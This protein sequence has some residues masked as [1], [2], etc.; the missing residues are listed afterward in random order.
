M[1]CLTMD[2]LSS[3][4]TYSASGGIVHVVDSQVRESYSFHD[5]LG[6]GSVN[7]LR[8]AADGAV[9]IATDSGLSRLKAGRIAT[10]DTRTGLP[11]DRVDST[12]IDDDAS[13]WLYSICGLVRIARQDLDAWT[14]AVDEGKTPQ[15]IQP[16][17]LDSSDGVR[18]AGALGTFSPHIT[19]S[20]DGKLWFMTYDGLSVVDPRHLPFNKLPPPVHVEQVVADHKTYEA[21]SQLHLPPLVR[22]L[23]IDYTALSL[24]APEKVRFRYKLEGRDHDWQ[25]AGNRR[26][27]FYND[28]DPG[29]YRFRVI[30]SNNSGVWNEDDA[31]LDFAIAPAYWQTTWFRALCVRRVHRMVL[32]L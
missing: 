17:V 13:T 27:A 4:A 6:K 21:S 5:G 23:Q 22:D 26:Q 1:F 18:S 19:K 10:L 32:T 11:C 28:L 25:D 9:W 16:M 7:D 24:V 3:N 30:A 31:S 2:A 15:R 14:A 8:V 20:R 12:I 29:D